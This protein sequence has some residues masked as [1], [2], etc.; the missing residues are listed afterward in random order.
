MEVEIDMSIP[1][2]S[3]VEV[4]VEEQEVM[5]PEQ[6]I[7]YLPQLEVPELLD[8][9]TTVNTLLKKKWKSDAPKAKKTTTRPTSKALLRNQA[10]LAHGPEVCDG[11][12]LDGLHD[13]GEGRGD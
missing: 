6:L 1:T 10:W 5:T 12:W 2:A 7:A 13:Q 11:E 3:E 9:L 8:V 4:E